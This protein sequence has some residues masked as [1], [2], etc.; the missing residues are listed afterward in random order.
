MVK[1]L[2]LFGEKRGRKGGSPPEEGG[3]VV[4]K[5]AKAYDPAFETWHLGNPA[6][7]S[8]ERYG[9]LSYRELEEIYFQSSIIRG[10]IDGIT[11]V[12]SSL[13][14]KIVPTRGEDGVDAR[15]LRAVEGFFMNPNGNDESF[16]T[17]VRK[18]V[19]D[20]LIY[21]AGVI[22]KVKGAGG[23]LLEI[24]ARDGST[25]EVRIDAHG[26]VTGY[27]QRVFSPAER[28][29]SFAPDEIV[30]LSLYPRTS[31]PYGSPPLDS[32]VNEVAA[33]MFASQLIAK[34]FEYDEVPPGILNLGKIGQVAY[35][36]AREYFKEKRYG[37]KKRFEIS[38]VHDTDKVEW[39]PLTRPPQELQLAELID[40]V[41]R[42][43]FRCFGVM[44]VEMGLV[45]GVNFATSRTQ[46]NI[47]KSKLIVPIIKMLEEYINSEIIWAHLSA[48]VR[49]HFSK[50]KEDDPER[51][52]KICQLVEK[53]I[54]TINEA[55][56]RLGEKAVPGGDKPFM[57]VGDEL[58]FVG[59]LEKPKVTKNADRENTLTAELKKI[60]EKT[61]RWLVKELVKA[62]FANERTDEIIARGCAQ[63]FGRM[64][65]LEKNNNDGAEEKERIL[66]EHF[67]PA[68]EKELQSALKKYTSGKGGTQ[69]GLRRALEE[70]YARSFHELASYL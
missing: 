60:H 36:R 14:W 61:G 25:F 5:G 26:L 17:L 18:V 67:L 3:S 46:E 32:L 39:V 24:Y 9:R 27:I 19:R 53:G 54:I 47:S 4:R 48:D 6:G 8:L 33:A 44:P 57:I 65:N 28:T 16:S 23:D 62:Y 7:T 34:S 68:V 2:R 12:I 45:E 38:I 51:S 40:K 22:E 49:I 1:L 52:L 30:Y 64:R 56:R 58:I 55:R 11:R 29:A 42:M 10:I 63:L 59:D 21:D 41:N 15:I 70:A 43:I 69:A 13:E 20:L 35:E 66:K 31:S 37:Q 50:P